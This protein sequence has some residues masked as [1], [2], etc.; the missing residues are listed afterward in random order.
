MKYSK[1]KTVEEYLYIKE[2]KI[3]AVW[4]SERTAHLPWYKAIRMFL[5]YKSLKFCNRLGI[6]ET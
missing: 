2:N 5:E 6:E 4:I 3:A 1:L